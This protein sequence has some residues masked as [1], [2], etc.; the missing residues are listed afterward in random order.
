MNTPQPPDLLGQAPVFLDAL[1]HA[2]D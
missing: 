1:A 2:S